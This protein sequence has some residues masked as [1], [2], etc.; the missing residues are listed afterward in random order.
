MTGRIKLQ[1][2]MFEKVFVRVLLKETNN[3]NKGTF[4]FEIKFIFQI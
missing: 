2:N 4:Y 1:G 3:F